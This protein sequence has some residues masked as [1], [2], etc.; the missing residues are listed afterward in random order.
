M[1]FLAAIRTFSLTQIDS[2]VQAIADKIPALLNAAVLP[3]K[4]AQAIT[5][6]ST[7]RFSGSSQMYDT[8]GRLISFG[9]M[10]SASQVGIL[11]NCDM[12]KPKLVWFGY[13]Y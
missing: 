10:A 7:A 1:T 3:W 8:R 11:R 6:S 2:A 13:F 12:K 4:H 5:A 9:K